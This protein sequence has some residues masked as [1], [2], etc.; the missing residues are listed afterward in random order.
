MNPRTVF[1]SVLAAL[2]LIGVTGLVLPARSEAQQSR[3]K[4]KPKKEVDLAKRLEEAQ[5]ALEKAKAE[6]DQLR[7]LLE[8]ERKRAV[9]AEREAL[10]QRDVAQ[11]AEAEARQQA[12]QARQ[13]AEKAFQ[14]ARDALRRATSQENLQPAQK[15]RDK[16]REKAGPTG[17]QVR[18]EQAA[19]VE[20]E[21]ERAKVLDLFNRQR[22]ELTGQLKRLE[23]EQHKALAELEAKAD[24]LRR[25]QGRQTE[26]G[27]VPAPQDKLD[28]ILERLDRMEKRLN[29]LERNRPSSSGK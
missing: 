27:R 22:E 11:N 3:R 10:T 29:Q 14:E 12:E 28:Q 8:K 6:A 18:T 17:A 24:Q 25:A 7:L 2:L 4:E 16:G 23:A 19:L 20:L 13:E 21:R 5:K 15:A 1:T 26:P 9:V